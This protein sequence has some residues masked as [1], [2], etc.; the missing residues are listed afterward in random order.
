V[1]GVRKSFLLSLAD[2]YLA[3]ALQIASAVIISRLLTPAEVGTFAIAAV[4]AALA[5]AFR[6]FGV[7]EYL[8][9]E[10]ELTPAKFRAALAL[11]IIV[12]WSMAALLALGAPLA[13]AFY[14]EEAVRAVIWVLAV[15]F[16][17]IPFGAVTLAWFRREL[18]Y[19]PIV[20]CNIASSI[21]AFVVAVGLAL[22]G[23]GTM[24]LAWSSLAGI[25]S[26]VLLAVALRP[27]ELPRW[28]SLQ[29]MA[30]VFHF[31]KF[32]S[33]ITVVA[34]LG[35]G[36]PELIIGRA[37]GAADVGIFSRAN[38]LVEVVNK[39]LMRPVLQICM[40]Y[41]AR[42]DRETG[43][44]VPA[45]LTSVSLLTAVGWPF[46][47]VVAVIAYPAIR[48][49]YGPQWLAAVPLAQMLC[50]AMAIDLVHTLSREALI[51]R[52]EVRRANTL[53]MQIVGA[54]IAGLLAGVPFGLQGAAWGL[55]MAAVAGA[56]LSQ[57]HLQRALGL[58]GRQML[59]A[60]RPSGWLAL[61]T[62]LPLAL[63]A[64]WVP[65]GEANFV[66][67]GLGGGAA[68]VVLWLGGLHLLRHR[69]WQEMAAIAIRVLRRSA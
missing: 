8:I 41:F 28:P 22:R 14:R 12:S 55:A 24:S 17:L 69:L 42:S 48:I 56:L 7:A 33:A 32:A 64:W 1:S 23:F 30:E 9:Q 27:R 68:A 3:I 11:N 13:A 18:N 65:P 16:L 45:Y 37:R 54:Q 63:A 53:Q 67:W 44:L 6:D 46:L 57:H 59:T 51:A 61:G 52:G 39:L 66:A 20:L 4:F 47:G 43:S 36:A 29:G 5:S 58:Q 40:P 34:Q 25:V 10:R 50:L 49:I 15:N 26:S 19:V 60:L 31:G 2:S 62:A 21:V 38:G 35:K